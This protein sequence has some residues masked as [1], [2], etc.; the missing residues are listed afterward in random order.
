MFWRTSWQY[1][2]VDLLEHNSLQSLFYLITKRQMD[3][4]K[5]LWPDIEQYNIIDSSF[6]I[7][8]KCWKFSVLVILAL[9]MCVCIYIAWKFMISFICYWYLTYCLKPDQLCYFLSKRVIKGRFYWVHSISLLIGF[10]N[11]SNNCCVSIYQFKKWAL[12][13]DIFIFLVTI[14]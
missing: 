12:G 9:I 2:I 5:L 1:F 8:Y 4:E 14:L 13:W 11:L 3:W 6:E 7:F 10:L